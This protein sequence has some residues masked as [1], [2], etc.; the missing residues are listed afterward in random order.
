MHVN[1]ND[2]IPLAAI[3]GAL[4]IGVGLI[5]ALIV[6]LTSRGTRRVS[7][8]QAASDEL[9]KTVESVQADLARI[10][11]AAEQPS[12]A[13]D[14]LARAFAPAPVLTADQRAGALELLRQGADAADVAA[15]IGIS[16]AE[17]ELLLRV[18]RFLGAAPS[19][20]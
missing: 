4:L 6:I 11:A 18:Q 17:A 14:P 9:R 20:A 7:R 16:H 10:Q 1:T 2:L 3:G 8:L 5:G 13:S 15:G 12:V 19:V